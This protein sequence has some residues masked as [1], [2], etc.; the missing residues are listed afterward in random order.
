MMVFLVQQIGCAEFVF[1]DE[2]KDKLPLRLF[3]AKHKN[4]ITLVS[5]FACC[6]SV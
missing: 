3:A 6:C 2:T 4:S 1:G 5:V